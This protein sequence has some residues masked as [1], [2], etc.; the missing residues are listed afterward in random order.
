[1][2]KKVFKFM[3]VL[4]LFILAACGSQQGDTGDSETQKLVIEHKLGTTEISGTPERVAVFDYGVLE[5]IGHLD[6]IQVVG[7]ARGSTSLPELSR[8]EDKEKY[9]TIGTLFEPNF[10]K[11]FE[12]KPDLILISRRQAPLYDD[13]SQIAPTVYIQSIGTSYFEDLSRSA[14]ILGNIFNQK[15][16]LEK[17]I[18][19]ITDRLAVIRDK[20][21]D[22]T[23][24]F[25]LA[26]GG[27]LSVYGEGSRY[28]HLYSAFGFKAADDNIEKA[29]HGNKVSYEYFY[30]KNPDYLFVLDKASISG[31]EVTAKETMNND[32]IRSLD[33]YKNDRIVY[34]SPNSWYLLMGGLKSSE[35]V[36]NEVETA[37]N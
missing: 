29:T 11:L 7:V 31:Q 4:S 5:M 35:T 24:L 20:A 28:D 27:T 23:A 26:D 32:I 34:V 37:I 21:K 30:E 2:F 12:L 15:D 3:T 9:P 17:K 14:E 13:L 8:F 1:M 25:V 10:E 16:I 36:V 33:A 18:T 19:E 22:H 6:D